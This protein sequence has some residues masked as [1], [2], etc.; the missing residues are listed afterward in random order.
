[1][2]DSRKIKLK[3][4]CL[5]C[6]FGGMFSFWFPFT[7]SSKNHNEKSYK[8]KP[9]IYTFCIDLQFFRKMM[10]I[11]LIHITDTENCVTILSVS[12]LIL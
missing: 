8:I 1:M 7:Q 11:Y 2:P 3:S 4:R 6:Y 5:N 10:Q 12:I 9:R